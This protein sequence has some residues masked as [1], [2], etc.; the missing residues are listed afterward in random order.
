[1]GRNAS[2][3]AEAANVD[4]TARERRDPLTNMDQKKRLKAR[5]GR[6]PRSAA[7]AIFSISAPPERG[8]KNSVKRACMGSFHFAYIS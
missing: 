2:T 1:M 4:A 3:A 8:D 6:T 5:N 7:I